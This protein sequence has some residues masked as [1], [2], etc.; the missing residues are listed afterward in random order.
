MV[1]NTIVFNKLIQTILV[2][3]EYESATRESQFVSVLHCSQKEL[4][5]LVSF[6]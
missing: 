6:K 2:E 1:F 3:I 5:L 4:C